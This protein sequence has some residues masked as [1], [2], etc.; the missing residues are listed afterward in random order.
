MTPPIGLIFIPIIP[1][2]NKRAT[3]IGHTTISFDKIPSKKK[4]L[5]EAHQI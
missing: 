4:E 5:I 1:E 3:T 2:V